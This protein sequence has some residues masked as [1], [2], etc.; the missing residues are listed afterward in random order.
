[1]I[2]QKWLMVPIFSYRNDTVYWDRTF[3]N[4]EIF[5]AIISEMKQIM[6]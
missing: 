6:H 5:R 3:G 4:I 1:M 2:R